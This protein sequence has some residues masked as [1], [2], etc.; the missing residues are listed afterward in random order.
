MEDYKN[1]EKQEISKEILNEWYQEKGVFLEEKERE[2][3]KS[4]EERPVP[5]PPSLQKNV[6]TDDEIK[7]EEE[8]KKLVVKNKIKYLLRLGEER[9]LQYSVK[10]AERENNPFLL[11]IY[12]DVLAKDGAYK[13]FL[14][15]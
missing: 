8:E 10:E 5:S 9:G 6:K 3:L 4:K 12:H 2:K 14:K 13:K 1:I 11:D 7:K 15:K